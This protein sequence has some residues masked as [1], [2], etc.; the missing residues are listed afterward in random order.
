MPSA[1]LIFVSIRRTNRLNSE[2][3]C[4]VRGKFRFPAK[5]FPAFPELPDAAV[6]AMFNRT[7]RRAN[8]AEPRKFWEL[9]SR[10][11]VWIL[12]LAEDGPN[13]SK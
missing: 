5:K 10:S 9:F 4:V 12:G 6:L 13:L 3:T 7:G 1:L 11:R 8:L 2:P